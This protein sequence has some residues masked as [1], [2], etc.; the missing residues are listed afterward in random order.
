[1]LKVSTFKFLFFFSLLVELASGQQLETGKVR[2]SLY[3]PQNAVI[4]GTQVT[5]ARPGF[6]KS[7]FPDPQTGQFA[8]DLKPGIYSITNKQNLWYST[9]RA[10][11]LVKENETTVVNLSPTLHVLS[12]ALEV[13]SKD[14]R[15]EAGYNYI[16][17]Y[18]DFLPF[19][20]SLLNVVI[21]Y[22]TTKTKDSI[23]EYTNAKLTYN[24]YSI[25]ANFLRFDKKNLS[26]EAL[27]NVTIDENGRR[28]KCERLE[29]RIEKR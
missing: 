13:R 24:D 4:L 15:E 1:M 14:L 22:R 7:V 17:K 10:V 8:F 12:V 25:N 16:P 23:S 6:Q 20:D 27:G 5:I 9:R 18:D 11:F 2:G 19:T 26:F 3:D 28:Q 29:S 21:E